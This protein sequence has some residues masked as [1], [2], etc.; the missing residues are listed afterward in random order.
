[1]NKDKIAKLKENAP[2]IVLFT[3]AAALT[4]S[5]AVSAHI[6]Y[7]GISTGEFGESFELGEII[8]DARE[9]LVNSEDFALLKLT[10]DEYMFARRNDAK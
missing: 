6:L 3:G 9:E 7:K 8:G 1:M 10:D 5:L 2:F 4:T